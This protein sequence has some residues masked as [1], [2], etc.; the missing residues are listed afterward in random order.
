MHYQYP[1]PTVIEANSIGLP[2]IQNLGLPKDELIEHTTTQSS[3]QAMLTAIE[4]R[5]QEQTLKI[6]RDFDQ[7]LAELAGYRL[8]DGSSR[9]TRSS[10][11]ASPSATPSARMPA[12]HSASTANS[13]AS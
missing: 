1:G 12:L 8:P 4:L 5:L 6:H 3:K 2:L 11:S 9:R 13:S 10:P 7:L